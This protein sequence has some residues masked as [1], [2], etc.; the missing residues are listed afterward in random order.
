MD[1]DTKNLLLVIGVAI[2]ALIIFRPKNSTFLEKKDLSMPS[3]SKT[4]KTD[5]DNAIISMEAMRAA[6]NNKETN[7][8]L[9]ELN[10]QISQDYGLKVFYEG[11]KLTVRDKNKT[12]IV[13]EK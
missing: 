3:S 1:K 10:N 12:I 4:S 2:A 5:Y 13:S 8:K 9:N 6:I 7:D 11:G